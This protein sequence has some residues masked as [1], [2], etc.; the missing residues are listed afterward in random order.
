MLIID[1]IVQFG[2]ILFTGLISLCAITNKKIFNDIFSFLNISNFDKWAFA[3]FII[4]VIA[5][6][7]FWEINRDYRIIRKGSGVYIKCDNQNMNITDAATFENTTSIEFYS[8]EEF[9]MFFENTNFTD[10]QISSISPISHDGILELPDT[11]KMNCIR[12]DGEENIIGIYWYGGNDILYSMQA[13]YENKSFDFSVCTVTAPEIVEDFRYQKNKKS[14]HF[15]ERKVYKK[16]G[17]KYVEYIGNTVI[18]NLYGFSPHNL[19]RERK[20]C[21]IRSAVWSVHCEET[22]SC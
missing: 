14:T 18:K 9:A 1:K 20:I 10:E 13:M 17:I 7:V 8:K 16:D 11:D 6:I 12:F 21:H 15:I 22:K 19:L 3:L 5:E 4:F 2:T